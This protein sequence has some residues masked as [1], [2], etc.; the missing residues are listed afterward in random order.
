M[1]IEYIRR[2][3]VINDNEYP[4]VSILKKAYTE[5]VKKQCEKRLNKA[6][7]DPIFKNKEGSE[8]DAIKQNKAYIKLYSD[9]FKIINDEENARVM[10]AV[11]RKRIKKEDERLKNKHYVKQN[12]KY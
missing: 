8:E 9:L 1:G 11:E 4:I 2:P 6:L 3:K 10:R 7:E 12:V 5:K